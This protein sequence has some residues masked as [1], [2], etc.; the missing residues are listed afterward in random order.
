MDFPNKNGAQHAGN[1]ESFL[2]QAK[3]EH[4]EVFSAFLA[5]PEEYPTLAEYMAKL[6]A[7][8]WKVTERIAKASW[9]NGIARGQARAKGRAS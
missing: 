7:A 2:T 5:K 6:E 1:G 9:K 8:A 3:G 4:A